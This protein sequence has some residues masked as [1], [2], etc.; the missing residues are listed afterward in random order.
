M[1]ENRNLLNT[2]IIGLVIFSLVGINF[3][4]AESQILP[5]DKETLKVKLSYDEIIPGQLTSMQTDFINPQTQQVQEHIDWS[6]SISKKT[7]VF[8]VRK[9][10]QS[11]T[12][13]R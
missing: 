7:Q 2:V 9:Y 13:Y 12:S 5:T 11:V 8:A 1:I 4:Y 3:A 6:F 10:I